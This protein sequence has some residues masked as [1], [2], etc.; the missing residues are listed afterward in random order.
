MTAHWGLLEEP[1]SDDEY[2]RRN[3]GYVTPLRRRE[4]IAVPDV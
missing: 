3:L 4:V 1:S 2:W